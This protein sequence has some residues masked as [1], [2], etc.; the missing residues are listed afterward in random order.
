MSVIAPLSLQSLS[1]M[2]KDNMLLGY[3]RGKVGSL[4]FARR[5][6]QQITRAY[7]A[8]PANPRTTGQ[9]AQR[10]LM[11][12]AIQAYRFMS[13]ICDH[14][15]EDAVGKNGNM[16]AFMSAALR[17]LKATPAK[18]AFQQHGERKL[19]PGPYQVSAGSL[20][21]VVAPAITTTIDKAYLRLLSVESDLA[22][23]A[24]V[25]AAMGLFE[26]GDMV[27]FPIIYPNVLTGSGFSFIRATLLATPTGTMSSSSPIPASVVKLEAPS[28]T[29][30][31]PTIQLVVSGQ[32]FTVDIVINAMPAWIPASGA[33]YFSIAAIR[34]RFVDGK[35]QRSESFMK[36]GDGYV[37]AP[38]YADALATYPQNTAP[39]LNGGQV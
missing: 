22:N 30:I 24:D 12:T 6:G 10:M 9:M 38:T 8:N 25:C 18:F 33:N 13:A 29:L 32:S 2:S 34:S 4:V 19:L 11:A 15:F 39:I 20:S 26:I 14:S 7:N 16:R 27:T 3:A 21:Q 5:S 36:M 23:V 37:P 35:W 28:G 31:E 1:T 17:D